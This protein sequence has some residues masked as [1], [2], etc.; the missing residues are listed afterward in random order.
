MGRY[1]CAVAVDSQHVAKWDGRQQLRGGPPRRRP[2]IIDS[3][4]VPRVASLVTPR[5]RAVEEVRKRRIT[6]RRQPVLLS[7][8]D[9]G[10][11]L[12]GRLDHFGA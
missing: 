9:D 4:Y 2:G 11:K 10:R 6:F 1:A 12:G 5:K 3:A 8:G 7:G